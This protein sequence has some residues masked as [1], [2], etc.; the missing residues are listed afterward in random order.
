MAPRDGTPRCDLA[1]HGHGYANQP[2]QGC[3]VE[4][5]RYPGG[6]HPFPTSGPPG[7]R[8]DYYARTL[9]WFKDHLGDPV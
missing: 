2:E 5:A 1:G 3:E 8:A 4:F 7:H 6:A 9:A